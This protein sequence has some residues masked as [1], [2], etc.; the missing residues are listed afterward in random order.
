MSFVHTNKKNVFNWGKIHNTMLAQESQLLFLIVFFI[1]GLAFFVMGI[2]L[3]L[4]TSRSPS[5]TEV[6]LLW[7]LAVF[8]ILHGM[9]EWVELFL[10]QASWMET[11]VGEM[12][13]ATRL[14][15]LAISFLSLALYGFQASQLSKR[16][17]LS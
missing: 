2:A 7:P 13:S 6:R 3:F 8:G 1:Y 15:L 12:V 17:T 9:H 4:E 16:E 14:I 10:L 11:P 5:L